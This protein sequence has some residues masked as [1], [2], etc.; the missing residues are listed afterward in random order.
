MDTRDLTPFSDPNAISPSA[1]YGRGGCAERS[2]DR[3]SHGRPWAPV[4]VGAPVGPASWGDLTEED[5]DT[6]QPGSWPD[7]RYIDLTDDGT[8]EGER[9]I[10]LAGPVPPRPVAALPASDPQLE[11]PGHARPAP[12]WDCPIYKPPRLWLVLA[13]LAVTVIALPLSKSSKTGVAGAIEAGDSAGAPAGGSERSVGSGGFAQQWSAQVPGVLSFLGNPSRSFAGRG[14]LPERP[15]VIDRRHPPGSGAGSSTQVL[16]AERS[17]GRRWAIT[18]GTDGRVGFTDATTGEQLLAPLELSRPIRST[19]TLDP[20]GYPLLYLGGDDGVVR[21]VALDRGATPEELWTMRSSSVSPSQWGTD[22]NGSP[23]LRDDLLVIGG[24][25]SN[26][27]L[28]KL[29]RALDGDGRVVVAPQLVAAL[30]TW[31]DRLAEELGDRETGV[32]ASVTLSGNTAWVVNGGGLLTGW[33]L[34]PLDWGGEPTQTFRFWVGDAVDTS[35]T[36]DET[37]AIYLATSGRR[38]NARTA[39]LGR[40]MKLDPTRPD[41]PLV[42]SAPADALGG[43][44]VIGAPMVTAG[45]VV[46]VSEEGEMVALD[47]PSGTVAWARQV[48]APAHATP[49]MVDGV[50]VLGSCDGLVRAWDLGVDGPTERWSVNAGGCIE[51]PVTAWDGRIFVPQRDGGMVVVGDH[52][53][54]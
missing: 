22:W 26:L 30:P 21:V 31:D 9:Y 46:V 47:R 3:A 37:G 4:V 24:G 8:Y 40:V 43:A 12:W 52:G 1:R 45:L 13:A 11:A 32:D 39:E 16:I 35:L 34:S 14:P 53:G 49:V 10:D 20:D 19:P 29:N 17:D 18:A 33:D 28:I 48:Q 5:F 15:R 2:P 7:D 6:P 44:G 51:S 42:W 41:D 27:H 23:M 36:L 38:D 54:G 50:M 25:N